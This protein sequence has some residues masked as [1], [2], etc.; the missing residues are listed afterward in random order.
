MMMD[1]LHFTPLWSLIGGLLIGIAA[2]LFILLHG[3]IMGVSGILGG[4]IRPLKGDVGWRVTFILGLISA[5]IGA[6]IFG[7]MP[8]IDIQSSPV[9]LIAAGL[10][11]GFGTVFGSGCTSGHGVCG[12]ARLSPRSIIA[13]ITFMITGILTVWVIRH[14]G[15]GG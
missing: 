9:Q 11:V 7:L 1:W 15:F 12:M 8:P 14:S 6:R 10:L 3:R 13:T 5:P 2:S 4:L